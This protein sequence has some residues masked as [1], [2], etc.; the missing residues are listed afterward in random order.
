MKCSKP[1]LRKTKNFLKDTSRFEQKGTHSLFC[2]GL[3][4]IVKSIS[5]N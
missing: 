2:I 4:N 5:S 3:L 1:Y